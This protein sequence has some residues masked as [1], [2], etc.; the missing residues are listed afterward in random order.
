M[1]QKGGGPVSKHRRQSKHKPRV[2]A[3]SILTA[4]V[5]IT[6]VSEP[7]ASESSQSKF[8]ARSRPGSRT[9][10]FP[11]S[12]FFLDAATQRWHQARAICNDL[13]K[14]TKGLGKGRN[15]SYMIWRQMGSTSKFLFDVWLLSTKTTLQLLNSRLVQSFLNI[16]LGYP[17]NRS[18]AILEENKTTPV[19]SS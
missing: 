9:L 12:V 10:N 8:H 16:Y 14:Q 13:Q 17:N 4:D 11:K 3:L 18:Q 2:R 19:P 6:A 5:N 15:S 7:Q 1:L